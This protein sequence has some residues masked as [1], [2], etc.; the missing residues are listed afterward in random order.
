MIDQ[1]DTTVVNV[2]VSVLEHDGN[3]PD[4]RKEDFVFGKMVSNSRWLTSL[5]S[6]SRLLL[7]YLSTPVIRLSECCGHS[8]SGHCFR[9]PTASR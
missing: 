8:P 6:T 5:R 2:P 7:L 1:V 4:L 3:V 9:G